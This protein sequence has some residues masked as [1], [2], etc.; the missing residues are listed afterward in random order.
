LPQTPFGRLGIGRGLADAVIVQRKLLPRWAVA[1]LRR[2]V[3][4]L[5]FDFD[6]A[7]WL[8]DSY[9]PR[10]F[11]DPARLRR[12]RA[13]VAAS[14]LVVAG[15]D[16]LAAEAAR[17]TAADRVV[18][19][20]TCVEPSKYPQA[21]HRDRPGLQ[22][23]WIGSHSTLRGLERFRRVLSAIGRTVPGT[24]LKL[25]CDRFITI[26]GLPVDECPWTEATE[27]AEIAS[28]DVGISWVPDDPWSRGKCG[29]K[30]LQYQAA[31]LPVVANPVGVHS[32][33]ILDG[34]TGFHATAAE[35]WPAAIRWLAN[36]VS[37]RSRFG[38]AGRRQVE[39]RYSVA[40]GA[41]EWM[42]ALARMAQPMR[43]SG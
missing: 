28:A 7:V 3:R 39:A 6:D 16:Y 1:L 2:R 43:K 15:N 34:E 18:V 12:F 17:H 25:I 24:R 32:Q 30:V 33:M 9:S 13:I 31:G 26:R 23:V 10:G 27:A 41:R 8:R 4:K 37:L 11:D 35:E 42:A 29:L 21:T 5:I 20:P 38:A 14:D 19:I 40:A 36:D 22:L